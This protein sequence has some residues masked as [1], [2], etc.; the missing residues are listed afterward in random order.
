MRM[1][2]IYVA[3]SV[4]ILCLFT[5]C[6]HADAYV[7]EEIAEAG[8]LQKG[9]IVAFGR[10]EQ[11]NDESN[12]PEPI[13]WTVINV[14]KD[15]VTLLSRYVIEMR[16]W[17][18]LNHW[19]AEEFRDQAFRSNEIMSLTDY[20]EFAY[21][22]VGLLRNVDA[23]HLFNAEYD[24]RAQATQY[25]KNKGVQITEDGYC[26]WWIVGIGE[27]SVRN[28]ALIRATGSTGEKDQDAEGVG[29][30]PSVRIKLKEI[31][32]LSSFERPEKTVGQK[33]TLHDGWI[34]PPEYA[35]GNIVTFGYYEQDNKK[36]N[37]KEEIEWIVLAHD[38]KRALL[39]S[40]Y[41]LDVKRYHEKNEP[42]T[43]E[44][45]TLRSW[46]NT[47]FYAASFNNWQQ[48]AILLSE[49]HSNAGN[50]VMDYVFIL[51]V[52]EADKY[53]PN[54]EAR[55]IGSTK[56]ARKQGA[57]DDGNTRAY[58][59]T[60]TR[61]DHEEGVYLFGVIGEQASI[62]NKWYWKCGYYDYPANVDQV[63]VRPAM[64]VDMEKMAQASGSPEPENTV[65]L[66]ETT[67]KQGGV[68]IL[69]NGTVN[70]RQKSNADS[71]R[72]G[73]VHTGEIYEYVDVEQ[74]GWVRI[75]LNDGTTG[76]ISGKMV[77]FVQ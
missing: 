76:Y 24:R 67:E 43:W 35:V 68:K 3:F 18:G 23:D 64:W 71:K 65:S 34:C 75:V 58:W 30:R 38:G 27:N 59:W 31:A 48:S 40:K 13:E 20:F 28:G 32:V 1:R 16:P 73:R 39:T 72:V 62:D 49:V 54:E 5:A 66:T 33:V 55:K 47:E 17:R 19:L 26:E 74:N 56:Y 61:G 53:F 60:R 11:D 29:V 10:Y 15:A 41:G 36:S 45:C 2:S 44:E 25:A 22:M 8:G 42:I 50:D 37:G 57:F 6:A 7:A 52:E 46:L 12:G 4:V 14:E 70:V 77:E 69:G 21:Q 51:S 9:D 63:T